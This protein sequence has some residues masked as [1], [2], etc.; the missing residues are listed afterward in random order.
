MR[1]R[2]TV[3]AAVAAVLAALLAAVLTTLLGGIAA[4]APSPSPSPAAP[5]SDPAAPTSGP[6]AALC[7]A[8]S[9][10]APVVVTV[11]TLLPRAPTRIDQA[12]Q[13][14]GRLTNCG[15]QDVDGLGVR[16]LVGPRIASR[17]G[18]A[19]ADKQPP[20]SGLRLPQQDADATVLVAGGSTT[21][22]FL[23]TVGA[24]QLGTQNGVWPLAVQA[25]GQTDNSGRTTLGAAHTFVPWFP[26]GPIAPTRV[27]WLLPLV[28]QPHRGP[29]EIQLDDDLTG[30]VSDDP[31]SRGRLFRALL[32]GVAGSR[33]GCDPVARAPAG[34]AADSAAGCRGDAV[35]M[36]YAVDPDLL[37][38]LSAMTSPYTVRTAGTDVRR[39]AS[40]AAARWL[41]ALSSA[42]QGKSG[43]KADILALPYGDPD[44]AA[45]ARSGTGLR[46]DI[47]LLR[48][49]GIAQ[50]TA[51]LKTA[52]VT[53]L[54]WPLPGPIGAAVD[55]LA[56]DP[57]S[58]TALVLDAS[59]FPPYDPASPRTPSARVELASPVA[60]SVTGLVADPTLSSLVEPDPNASSWQGDRLAEQRW[61]AEIAAVT[62]ETPSV[63]RTLVV[64]PRRRAD[65][66]PSVAIG[67]ILDT[68]RLPF[69]CGV[70]LADAAAGRE[71][72]SGIVDDQ[73]PA[74][75]D[76]R[77][78]PL[79]REGD[80]GML[81]DAF[82]A[83]LAEVRRASDQFTDEVL[84]DGSQAASISEARLLRARGRAES[85]AWRDAPGQGRLLLRLL[86]EDVANLR[87]KISLKA[88]PVLLTGRSGPVLLTVEN[89]L[90]QPV[91]IGVQLDETAAA[92]LV[93]DDKAVTSIPGSST[94][95]IRIGVTARTSGRFVAEAQ[96]VDRSGR[97]F[98]PPQSF[99]VTASS[100]GPAAL[101][102]T[103]LAAGVLFA[104]VGVRLVRRALRRG[105]A[106]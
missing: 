100:Y 63:S 53:S 34:V 16:L 57:T 31:A 67:T 32:S 48:K 104:A 33:G 9:P 51:V 10:Q 20:S 55:P 8:A 52:P 54:A 76:P 70:R 77:G 38:T 23:T 6:P 75:A 24:L 5:T 15:Q 64:A 42:A 82:V 103:G 12:L 91:N 4:A 94:R 61:I 86:S 88:A 98:G 66:I 41:T 13:V 106:A 85:S 78:T 80:G 2:L 26:D 39:P 56:G 28:D 44:V 30:L 43:S 99:R 84:L 7:R 59:A 37:F 97:P 40:E 83:D 89:A 1:H 69:L 95:Q 50:T 49:L 72:C 73:P 21:F 96:L 68:G 46:D 62:A 92:R 65:L 29:G 60:G 45:L 17:S 71:Q 35:P 105:A 36:T 47:E 90:D 102:I 14:S 58:P 25:R 3:L 81:S 22:S 87:S 11:T 19:L 79:G 93:S 27:A 101:G 18:L 74:A